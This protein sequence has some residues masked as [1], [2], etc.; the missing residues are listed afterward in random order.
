VRLPRSAIAPEVTLERPSGRPLPVPLRA[1][2]ATFNHGP[3]GVQD[4]AR[5]A[6]SRTIV[7][8]VPE[9]VARYPDG[10]VF[11]APAGDRMYA[12][13]YIL[14]EYEPEVSDAMRRLL[15]PGDLAVDVGANHGWYS[16]LMGAAV[17]PSGRVWAVEPLPPLLAELRRNVDLNDS[18]PIEVKEIALGAEDGE[19]EVH[20]F[21]GLPHG[22]ASASTLGR[23]DY[24]SFKAP[25]K[26]LDGIAGDERPALIKIDVEGGEREVLR[27]AQ[28]V[29]GRDDA[30][31]LM[32]EVNHETSAAFGYEP[33]ELIDLLPDG[34]GYSVLRAE[35]GGLEPD[36]DPRSAPHGAMWVCVPAARR[37]RVR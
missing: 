10:R 11:H 28:Q 26:T 4:F 22:H 30:P 7:E 34:P 23:D 35:H 20:L 14:G 9:L 5:R 31:I 2:R 21:E 29:L 8:R 13:V 16:V 1:F 15:R 18:L 25:M 19:L 36:P 24:E 6:A 37:D 32:L 3:A 12:Q 33:H 27:G 17:G